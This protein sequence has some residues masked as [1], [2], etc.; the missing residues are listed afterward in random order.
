[1]NT[2]P[3][4]S[5]DGRYTVEDVVSNYSGRTWQ[6]VTDTHADN[7]GLTDEDAEA[8]LQASMERQERTI[9]RV[10]GAEA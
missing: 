3:P 9:E 6:V 4:E 1:M 5:E 10:Y 8:I 2:T 7:D